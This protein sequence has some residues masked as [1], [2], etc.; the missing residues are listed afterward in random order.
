MNSQAPKETWSPMNSFTQVGAYG[1]TCNT[2]CSSRQY[3]RKRAGIDALVR[4]SS[5]RFFSSQDLD[6]NGVCLEFHDAS[7]TERSAA[8]SADHVIALFTNHRARGESEI[9]PGRFAPYSYSPGAINVFPA[10]SIPACRPVTHTKMIICSIDPSLVSELSAESDLRHKT[11]FRHRRNLRD[12]SLG[13]LI[14]LLAD[15]ARSGGTSGRLYVELLTRALALRFLGLASDTRDFKLVRRS[16]LPTFAL[17]RVLE[18]MELEAAEDLDLHTLARESGYS[19]SQFLRMF[20][21][22]M[23][24]SPHQWLIQ[25]RIER[26]KQMLRRGSIPL[27]EI[28]AACGFSSHAHLSTSFRKAVGV[29][30]NQYRRVPDLFM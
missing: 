25:L 29:S 20:R 18:K 22:S 15:E 6:W 23:G 19:K 12:S 28:A 5:T 4:G 7:P 10:G 3:N 17:S 27:I 1:T 24:C 11:E 9:S 30:P 16:K 8:S 2:S 21:A 14:T 13:N 26:V